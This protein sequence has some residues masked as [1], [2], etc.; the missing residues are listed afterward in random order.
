MGELERT[1]R[2]RGKRVVNGKVAPIS[3]FD[4]PL[5]MTWGKWR[6]PFAENVIHGHSRKASDRCLSTIAQDSRTTDRRRFKTLKIGE[7]RG[8]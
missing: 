8:S 6:D 4:H 7:F 5:F 3:R 2:S 1:V